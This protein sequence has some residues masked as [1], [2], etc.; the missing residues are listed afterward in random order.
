MKRFLFACTLLLAASMVI[1]TEGLAQRNPT[2]VPLDLAAGTIDGIDMDRSFD[3]FVAAVKEAGH[4]VRVEEEFM[5]NAAAYIG[6]GQVS[7][8]VGAESPRGVFI[9]SPVFRTE[10]NLGVGSTLA[11]FN[12]IY[13]ASSPNIYSEGYPASVARYDVPQ[14]DGATRS[15][16]AVVPN[17][18]FSE[19]CIVTELLMTTSEE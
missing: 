11:D 4:Y 2:A 7:R 3:D 1:P 18:C 5:K 13:G 14:D 16:L 12:R 19:D 10:D 15:V 17:G 8:I 6:G 9:K